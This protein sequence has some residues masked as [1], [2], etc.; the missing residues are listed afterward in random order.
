M[1][2][3]ACAP[4]APGGGG[5]EGASPRAQDTL[6]AGAGDRGT[7]DPAGATLDTPGE[8]PQRGRLGTPPETFVDS[9]GCPYECCVYRDW[10]ANESVPVYASEGDTTRIAFALHA[11]ERFQALTGNVHVAP[12]GMALVRRDFEVATQSGPVRRYA[13]GDT[14]YVLSYEGEGV[15]KLWH[16]GEVVSQEAC[17]GP[18]VG[19]PGSPPSPCELLREP[20]QTWWVRVRNSA[21]AEGWIDME[22]YAPSIGNRDA[23]G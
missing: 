8:G 13:P 6:G 15:F 19:P 2:L 17:W 23:C 12:T 18:A 1:W 9:G 11:V 22:A 3:V 10:V 7:A 14:L 4:D 16:R 21:G 20:V 5:G